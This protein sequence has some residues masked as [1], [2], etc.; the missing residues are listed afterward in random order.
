LSEA[1]L[2]SLL[3]LWNGLDARRRIIVLVATLGMF[4]AVLGVARMAGAPSMALLYAGLD[5]SAA[6]EVVRALDQRG[7]RFEVRGDSIYVPLADRD[8]LRMSLAGEGLPATGTA[9]Y[10]LLDSLSG[11]GTT[12][13][14][15]DAAYLRAKEG[16]L[17]RTIVSSPNIRAAR[18]HIAQPQAQP[19]ARERTATASVTVTT[20][21]GS[22]PPEQ[23][24]ALKY[25]VAAAV[26]GLAPED[27]AIIDAAGGLLLLGDDDGTPSRQAADRATEM[28][29]NLERLLA[30]RVGA[31]QALVEVSVD[32]VTE[33][34]SLLERRFDPEGRVPVS[35]ETESRSSSST[36][37][38]AG[39]TV[40][41]NLPEGDAGD[42]VQSQSNSSQTRERVTYELSA[43]TR[44]LERTPG[45]VR[46]L[47][48]AVLVDGIRAEDG[49]W[50]PR[51]DAELTDLRDLVTSAVGYDEARGDIVT[52]KSMEFDRPPAEGTLVER[53]IAAGLDT[54]ALIQ[55]AIIALVALI[56]GLFVVRPILTARRR[57]PPPMLGRAAPALALP[58][59]RASEAVLPAALTGEIDDGLDLPALARGVE[60]APP[61]VRGPA[62]APTAPAEPD[63]PDPVARLRT[64]ISERRDEALVILRAWMDEAEEQG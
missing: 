17:A 23:I 36:G 62:P 34:E 54:M 21:Q 39:V 14:M 9:G 26:A 38:G 37:E 42:G 45:A 48:V 31:G 44:A 51:S 5:P 32:L 57:D 11:F 16:E 50:S 29:Q 22:L 1:A 10:E 13:Q 46:R 43:T 52:I 25:L 30:A 60:A 40:A 8:T 20:A 47:S 63:E 3:A 53:S 64:L 18:V 55:M 27:V 56:L 4:L 12:T 19:F 33:R 61:A 35:T 2:Q 15:F 6:G 58:A 7:I 59:G 49:T 28:R 41:S 24:R